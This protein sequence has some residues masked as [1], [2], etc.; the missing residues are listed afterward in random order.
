M[1]A[2]RTAR[3][4][5]LCVEDDRQVLEELHRELSGQY[6]VITA[7]NAAEGLRVLAAQS[8]VAAIISDTRMPGMDGASFL[9]RTRT[10]APAAGRILLTDH[11][12]LASAIAA[13]NEAQILRFLSKPFQRAELH[14]AVEAALE[15]HRHS[16]IENTG[17]MRVITAQIT[18]QDPITGLASRSRFLDLLE[19][20]CADADGKDRSSSFAVLMIS[21]ENLRDIRDAQNLSAGDQVMQV[22]A[23]RLRDHC[24]AA[25]CL[26]RWSD[27]DF[28]VLLPSDLHDEGGVLA[29]AS[30]LIGQL[31]L[32]IPLQKSALRVRACIGIAGVPLHTGD[33]RTAL[34]FADIAARQ[35]KTQGGAT[36]CLFRSDWADRVAYRQQLLG[37]LR[38]ALDSD[39]LHVNYQPI[40]DLKHG[41]VRTL[42][43]L[44]R[45]THPELGPIAPAQFIGLAEE[46]GEMPRLGQWILRRVCSDARQ[47]AGRYCSRVAVNVS[48][49][50]LLHPGFL[51]QLDEALR[52][53]RLY[54]QELEIELTESVLAS[55]AERSLA[56]VKELRKRGVSVAIDDF[57]TGY[58]SLAYLQRFPADVIK[59]DRSF[60]TALGEGGETIISAA[61]SI[62]RSFGMNVVI[63]GVETEL[64]RRQLSALGATLFQGYLFGKPMAPASVDQWFLNCAFAAGPTQVPDTASTV[65]L[66]IPT[67][68]AL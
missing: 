27:D 38:E 46:S 33:A 41:S 58:S 56:L 4:T 48:M 28:A 62:G 34:R 59:V 12:D 65:E 16:S 25:L 50:Q 30:A 61:L 51:P 36:A 37:A 49:H 40:V 47:L 35:A 57:G 7:L 53:A 13:V 39:A 22:L 52:L 20:V 14:A 6:Q 44:A 64:A 63:E 32:P 10:L 17:L 45:W 31:M 8:A 67:A 11:A 43:A 26:A 54:P 29:I 42:E 23:R 19:T 9:A 21:I 60:V 2:K 5:I 66:P 1:T 24:S 55:D 18:S 15:H 68:R 3:P